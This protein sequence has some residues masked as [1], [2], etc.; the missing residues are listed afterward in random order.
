MGGVPKR[1]KTVCYLRR[2]QVSLNKSVGCYMLQQIY[3]GE[4]VGK[5]IYSCKNIALIE[6]FLQ[7]LRFSVEKKKKK[8]FY[9]YIYIH[10]SFH[11]PGSFRWKPGF[12]SVFFSPVQT[13]ACRSRYLYWSGHC[14]L[15]SR[16]ESLFTTHRVLSLGSALSW[17]G[18]MGFPTCQLRVP[19]MSFQALVSKFL[20]QLHVCKVL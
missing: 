20:F 16:N 12:W 13:H 4:L 17:A 6:V 2:K 14:S 1:N 8:V 10:I 15:Y 5:L 7:A 9:I 18:R 19:V 11:L 3:V